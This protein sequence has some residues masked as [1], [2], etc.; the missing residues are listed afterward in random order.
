MTETTLST[1]DFHAIDHGQSERPI[2]LARFTYSHP[3]QSRF[4]RGLIRTVERL[5]GR[6]KLQGLYLD[7]A[8]HGRPEGESVFDAALRLLQVRPEIAC[9]EHLARIPA[10]G[11]VL[12]VANHPF[13]IL[14][15]LAIGQLGMKLRGNVRILTNSL[16]CQVHEIAPH[17]LPVDFSGTPEARR[18]TGVTRRRAVELLS[19]GK[20]VAMFPAGGVATANAPVRGRACDAEWHPFLSRLAVL[21]GVTTLP[22]HFNGQNSRLFQLASHMSYPLR[23]ALIFHET[24]RR[25]GHDLGLTLGRPV[26]ADELADL[27]RD[28]IPAVLRRLTMDLAARP[29]EDPDEVFEWPAHV[30]W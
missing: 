1:P 18:Q 15:G 16:L 4:R 17:L 19:Q 11:G 28:R 20:V 14:D 21:P 12:I 2:P 22:V 7:W 30:K 25:M 6:E 9:A 13:G 23:V 10:D 8:R 5:S 24:R 27:P 3:G 26:T 29:Y